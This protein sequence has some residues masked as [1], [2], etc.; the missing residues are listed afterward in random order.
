MRKASSIAPGRD[1]TFLWRKMSRILTVI[2]F[3]QISFALTSLHINSLGMIGELFTIKEGEEIDLML[4]VV[5]VLEATCDLARDILSHTRKLYGHHFGIFF[6]KEE[7][8]DAGAPRDA[9]GQA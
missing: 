4:D 9:S 2:L 1:V 7:E 5:G 8:R 6:P 3:S